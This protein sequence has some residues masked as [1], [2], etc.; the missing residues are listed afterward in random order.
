MTLYSFPVKILEYTVSW[1]SLN[2]F[3]VEDIDMIHKV[4][5]ICVDPMVQFRLMLYIWDVRTV[6]LINNIAW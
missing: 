4:L 2:S 1:K 6:C 5:Y 3:I